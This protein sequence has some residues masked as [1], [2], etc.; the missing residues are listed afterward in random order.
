MPDGI[1]HNV[2]LDVLA[3]PGML[4]AMENWGLIIS[5]YEIVYLDRRV[6]DQIARPTLH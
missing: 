2:P 3:A 5:A 4:G 6:G 1:A